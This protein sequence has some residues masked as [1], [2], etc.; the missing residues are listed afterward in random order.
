MDQEWLAAICCREGNLGEAEQ[1]IRNSVAIAEVNC[2][3]PE[4]LAVYLDDYAR[5][6]RLTSRAVEADEIDTRV[7]TLQA[8]LNKLSTKPSDRPSAT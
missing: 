5:F 3:R 4:E 7:R 6:L 2:K 8:G 1:L